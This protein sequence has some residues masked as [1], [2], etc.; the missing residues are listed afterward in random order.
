M[1]GQ[2]K[3]YRKVVPALHR[4]EPRCV[5]LGAGNSGRAAVRILQSI[6][7]R[8]ALVDSGAIT[9]PPACDI[10]ERSATLPEGDF[11]LCVTSPS[12]PLGHPFIEKCRKRSIPVISEMELGY[13]FWPGRLLAVTGSKGKSSIVKLCAE[14]LSA[15]GLRAVPCGNYGTPLCDVALDA[16]DAPWAVAETSSFQLEHVVHYKPD[17]AILLNIQADHLDRHGTM[18]EYAAAKFRIFARQDASCAAFIPSD[19]DTFG[20]PLPRN[21]QVSTFGSDEG[22]TWR[23]VSGTIR[24]I[25]Q[26]AHRTIDIAGTW[27]D[28]EVL[29][30]GAAAAAGALAFAGLDNDGIGHI[31]VIDFL[32]DPASIENLQY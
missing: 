26:G 2:V 1:S 30:P 29:G 22:A 6:G 14:T 15:A 3:D 5:V 11:D 8:V 28:N 7:A 4:P 23:Y 17:A 27:F 16:P 9:N 25:A 32:L 31:G 12:I 13:A 19:I 18:E 20:S 21:V 24:G 10:F